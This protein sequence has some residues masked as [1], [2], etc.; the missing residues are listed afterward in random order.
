MAFLQDLNCL[1]FWFGASCRTDT[2]DSFFFWP[3]YPY[4]A[5][6][7]THNAPLVPTSLAAVT[8]THLDKPSLNHL[9]IIPVQ[10]PWTIPRRGNHNQIPDS[11][12]RKNTVPNRSPVKSHPLSPRCSN[13]NPTAVSSERFHVFRQGANALKGV[14]EISVP[15]TW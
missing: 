3:V 9:V 1:V 2:R 4:I 14:K 12:S 7:C 11:S 13:H 15:E 10:R 8:V 5:T 6:C